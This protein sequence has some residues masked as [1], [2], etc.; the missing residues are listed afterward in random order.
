MSGKI[1]LKEYHSRNNNID[2]K[3]NNE[4]SSES[5]ANDESVL[6][7]RFKA[8]RMW[9]GILRRFRNGMP[10]KR[11]RRQ[12]RTYEACFTGR[13]AID[14]LMNELPKFISEDK[15]IT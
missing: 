15:E 6:E 4:E 1:R 12:L 10:L 5:N 14:F 7:G 8:T 2:N 11:H 13:E 3:E 9:N